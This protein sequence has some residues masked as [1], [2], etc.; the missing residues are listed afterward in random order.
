[1]ERQLSSQYYGLNERAGDS[2]GIYVQVGLL[3]D[4]IFTCYQ[5]CS[6]ASVITMCSRF[7]YSKGSLVSCGGFRLLCKPVC[8]CVNSLISLEG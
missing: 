3:G 6:I 1:M 4:A 5:H 8:C 7:I 2:V